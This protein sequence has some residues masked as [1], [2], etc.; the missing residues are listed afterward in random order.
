MNNTATPT[1]P[2]IQRLFSIRDQIARGEL[3]AAAQALNEA[4][5]V[6]PGDP[7]LFILGTL[8]AE[9]SGNAKGAQEIARRAVAAAPRWSVAVIELALLLARQNQFKE[10][11]E[12]AHRAVDL[13]PNDPNMLMHG[14]DIAHRAQ[15]PEQ[16]LQWLR[17]ADALVP[18]N[19]RIQHLIAQDLAAT[20]QR[21]QAL[22]AL[23]ALHEAHPENADILL[24]ATKAAISLQKK[25]VSQTLARRLVALAPDNEEYKFWQQIAQGKTPATQIAGDVTALFDQFAE[26]FD[27]H[28]VRGLQYQMPRVIA[29]RIKVRYP[30]LKLNVLDLGCGTG[31]LGVCLGRIDGALVGVDLSMKMI[32]QAARHGVYDRFHNVNLLDALQATPDSLYEV[33]TAADVFIYV[34]DLSQAIPNACR[35]LVPGGRLMFSCEAA[36]DDEADY[37]LHADNM[38]Y[39]HKASHVQALCKA[40]GFDD[41]L[42]EATD[43]R[44]EKG[45]PVKGF[46]VEAHKPL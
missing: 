5:K 35:I 17:R 8:M 12:Q 11:L 39:A 31:L 28:L 32:E 3:P 20:G 6:S 41:V 18:G 29:E 10:A 34:G 4:Q 26:K 1:D 44:L 23:T 43:L 25:R 15:H 2:F 37:V 22:D 24:D 7:R 38:R 33:I 42:I 16:A 36:T 30:G 45:Q 40:A 9:K 19:L 21:A 13:A 27:Q 46:I 14:V